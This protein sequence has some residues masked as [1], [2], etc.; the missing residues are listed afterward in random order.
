MVD[1]G[2]LICCFCDSLL[3]GRPRLNREGTGYTQIV[4]TW[5]GCMPLDLLL[6]RSPIARR[7]FMA[8]TVR[9]TAPMWVVLCWGGKVYMASNEFE[10]CTPHTHSRKHQASCMIDNISVRR[11]HVGS[12]HWHQP[13]DLT[14]L[15]QIRSKRFF[16]FLFLVLVLCIVIAGALLLTKFAGGTSRRLNGRMYKCTGRM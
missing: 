3:T 14:S 4:R 9:A 10:G 1:R 13:V 5:N 16:S 2:T 11:E 6:H 8:E 12:C 15:T 7:Q